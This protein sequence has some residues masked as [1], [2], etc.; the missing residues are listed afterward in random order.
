MVWRHKFI[1]PT[2]NPAL[3]V[4]GVLY[5]NIDGAYALDSTN[6]GILWHKSLGFNQSVNFIPSVVIDGVDY[7]AST[8]GG[9]NSTLYALNASN[10][11][12]YWH[13][14]IINQISPLTVV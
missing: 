8:D 3:A 7:L 6:G 14:P 10:G 12:E 9:G 5:I 2:Y 11:E 4:N 1:Y 13:I